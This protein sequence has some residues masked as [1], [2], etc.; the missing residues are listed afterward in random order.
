MQLKMSFLL[1]FGIKR[2]SSG[3]FQLREITKLHGLTR[4]YYH[5]VTMSSYFKN[6][7]SQFPHSQTCFIKMYISIAVQ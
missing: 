5:A 4:Q 2:P 1:M 7:R 6:L 3:N